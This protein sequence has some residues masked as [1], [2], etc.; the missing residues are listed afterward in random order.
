MMAVACWEL[1]E[2]INEASLPCC[3][4]VPPRPPTTGPSTQCSGA[5]SRM[6]EVRMV[7]GWLGGMDGWM[8]VKLRS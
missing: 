4:P 8:L 3:V 6:S 1:Q 2:G 5:M 7:G